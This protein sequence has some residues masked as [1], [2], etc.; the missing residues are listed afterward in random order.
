LFQ[1]E[2]TKKEGDFIREMGTLNREIAEVEHQK[3]IILI[4]LNIAEKE[5]NNIQSFTMI[6]IERK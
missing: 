6:C 5:I 2:L 1:K 4:I 3:N